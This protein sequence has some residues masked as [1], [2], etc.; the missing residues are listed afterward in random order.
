MRERRHHLRT[1][2]RVLGKLDVS[3]PPGEVGVRAW[4]RARVWVWV[5]VRV[6]RVVRA[7]GERVG[8]VFRD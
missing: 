2:L 7:V 4:A 1:A 3:G 5:G 6:R 8:I